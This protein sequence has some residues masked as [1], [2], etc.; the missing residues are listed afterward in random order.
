MVFI[1]AIFFVD[2]FVTFHQWN[3]TVVC[4][5][6]YETPTARKWTVYLHTYLVQDTVLLWVVYFLLYLCPTCHSRLLILVTIHTTV[7]LFGQFLQ[8]HERLFF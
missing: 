2:V 7:I 8:I 6:Y 3:H 1:F 5:H 4:K